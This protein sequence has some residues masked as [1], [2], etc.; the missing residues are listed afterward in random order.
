MKK[1]RIV[2]KI[3]SSSL[4]NA[5]GGLSNKKMREHTSA[6]AKLKSLG[7][8]VVLISSGAVAAGFTDLGYPTRP[9]TIAGKQ[10][11][12]AV[13]QGLLMRVYGELF[14]Q[15][16]IV[17]AQLLLT[18][19]NF[20]NKDQYKN[21]F[22]TFSELLQR[23]VLPIV[24]END[25]VAVEELT[26]GDND[27]LSAL[28]SGIV[29]ADLLIILTDINGLFD[30]NPKH[31]PDA[32]KYHYLPEIT[33]DILK[34]TGAEG[35]KFGTGGMKSKIEAAQTALSLGINTFIGTGQGENKLLDILEG[36]GDGTYIGFSNAQ[37]MKNTKQWIAI[38]SE[39]SGEIIVDEGAQE[40]LLK[41]GKS[42][43]P[44]GI[45]SVKGNFNAS[46]VVNV[47]NEKGEI[48]G[49][50]QVNYSANELH[51]IK[52]KPSNEAQ[53]HTN[54]ASAVVIHRNNWVTVIKEQFN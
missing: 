40:A 34:S 18:R 42:L 13:G 47:L 1:Q 46:D 33:E 28:V 4:T 16:S 5:N 22:Q 31:S 52:G 39:V 49:R 7:H 25:S 32:K 41:R 12:A 15:Y 21:I 27:M 23:S 45:V 29:N 30:K 20:L 38:H 14:K 24:N 9:V 17:T 53:K 37:N 48:I 10:S 44:A 2:V 11:A 6:I 26:F 36:K 19:N 8:E 43:L 51:E 50:G 3:G 54:R 35:S